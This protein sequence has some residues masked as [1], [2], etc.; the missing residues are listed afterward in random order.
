MP[1]LFAG[2]HFS[3][4]IPAFEPKVPEGWMLRTSVYDFPAAISPES[5]EW[6]IALDGTLHEAKSTPQAGR[7]LTGKTMKVEPYGTGVVGTNLGGGGL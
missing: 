1:Y 4:G 2:E 6:I 5:V 7:L 3:I